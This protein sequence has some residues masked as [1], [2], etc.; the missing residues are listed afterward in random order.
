MSG[1]EDN[2]IKYYEMGETY[3][4]HGREEKCLQDSVD[5]PKGIIQ[6]R[7]HKC[8]EEDILKLILKKQDGRLW[9]GFIWLRAR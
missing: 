8:K 7:R 4:T 6:F 2:Q 9:I 1:Y 5:N 3:G